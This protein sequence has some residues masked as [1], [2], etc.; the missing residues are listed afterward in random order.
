MKIKFKNMK[1]LVMLLFFPLMVACNWE[2]LPEYDEAEITAVQYYYRW[3]SSAKDPITGEPIV[4]EVR[5][6]TTSTINSENALIETNVTI[7][8]ASGDFTEEVRSQVSQSNLC[9]QVSLSAAARLTPVEGSAALGTPDDWT[10]ERK[11]KVQAADGKTK[12]WTIKIV[13]F[14]K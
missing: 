1:W 9:A 4:K 12:V 10:V 13:S 3:A 6:N 8:A 5:L 14:V 2:D 7:P 11:Y